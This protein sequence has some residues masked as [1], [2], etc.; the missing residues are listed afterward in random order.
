MSANGY[1]IFQ[2]DINSSASCAE[3]VKSIDRK[4]NIKIV[5]ATESRQYELPFYYLTTN[6]LSTEKIVGR[7]R[8]NEACEIFVS[9]FKKDPANR[10]LK[11]SE[12]E[13]LKN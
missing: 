3:S 5:C 4:Q 8:T 1:L 10:L 12:C 13:L 6:A 7:A 2:M 9:E 11:Y